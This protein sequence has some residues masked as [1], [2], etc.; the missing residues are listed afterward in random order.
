MAQARYVGALVSQ[1]SANIIELDIT[2]DTTLMF[3]RVSF[4]FRGGTAV[5]TVEPGINR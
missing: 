2:Q 1:F 5:L 3:E 4:P